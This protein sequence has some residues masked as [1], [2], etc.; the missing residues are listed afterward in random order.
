MN[1]RDRASLTLSNAM[2]HQ[3]AILDI[4]RRDRRFP[5]E[6]YEFLE[7]SLQYT[8]KRLGRELEDRQSPEAHHHISGPELVLGAIE[9]A[10]Q[11]F[12]MLAATV[13]RMWK[14]H[15][16]DDLGEIVFNLIDAGLLY[17]NESDCREQF[18]GLFDLDHALSEDFA[19]SLTETPWA[20]R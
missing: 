12:G 9:F 1:A 3:P 14:L 20:K 6:A 10:K 8:Q 11:E 15:S 5:Y 13:F 18:H 7:E 17:R 2:Q 19:I 16:T 4:V